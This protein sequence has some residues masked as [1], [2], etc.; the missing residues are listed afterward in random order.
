MLR[1]HDTYFVPPE[2]FSFSSAA[3]GD[4]IDQVRNGQISGRVLCAAVYY[5]DVVCLLRRMYFT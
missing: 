3:V 4:F 2:A 1:Q 5:D